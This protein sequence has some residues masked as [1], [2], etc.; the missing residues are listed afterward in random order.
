MDRESGVMEE[1]V[2]T[3]RLVREYFFDEEK[4]ELRPKGSE[5]TSHAITQATGRAN[6]NVPEV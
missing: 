3:G 6:A 4:F 5:G 2:I 1:A